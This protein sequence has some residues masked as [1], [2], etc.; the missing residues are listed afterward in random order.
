MGKDPVKSVKDLP[1]DFEYD[2]PIL[3]ETVNI[4]SDYADMITKK[5]DVHSIVARKDA[6]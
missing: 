1:T 6:E 4:A 5:S 3:L 2:D